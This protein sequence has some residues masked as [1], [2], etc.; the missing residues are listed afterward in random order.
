M[1]SMFQVILQTWRVNKSKAMLE[2]MDQGKAINSQEIPELKSRSRFKE[3]TA[4]FDGRK[5]V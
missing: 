1:M 5:T 2:G 4:M 3:K